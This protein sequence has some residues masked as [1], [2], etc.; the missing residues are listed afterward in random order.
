MSQKK[1]SPKTSLIIS[2]YNNCKV[3]KLCL[4]SLLH[5]SQQPNEIVI[6]DDG[7]REETRLAIIEFA[8]ISPVPVIHVWHEDI[9]F[10]KTIILNKAIAKCS[11]EYI[12][13]IDGDILL[14]KDFIKDHIRFAKIGTFICGSRVKIKTDLTKKILNA[15]KNDIPNWWNRGLADPLNGIR[16]SIL[17]PLLQRWHRS[18]KLYVRGC[19]MAFWKKDC[20]QINGYNEDIIGW[21]SEDCEFACRLHHIGIIKRFLK[22]AAIAYHLEHLKY[23]KAY[24]NLNDSITQETIAQRKTWCERGI[25]QYI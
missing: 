23:S 24:L 3:L 15:K 21:G 4:N 16:C 25:S 12:I 10:R 11:N 6:A 22:F 19:N 1:T 13:Q 9:G 18:N 17:T 8:K 7:S 5:Q 20:M 14:H 2:T